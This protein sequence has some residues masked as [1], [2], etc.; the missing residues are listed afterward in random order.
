[1]AV[2]SRIVEMKFNYQQFETGVKS[3]LGALDRLAE[4]LHL[5]GASKGMDE[6]HASTKKL[7]FSP[8]MASVDS[9]TGRFT[10]LGVAGVAALATIAN[11]AVLTGQRMI[12]SVT[13]EPI[14]GGLREYETKLG[15]IQTIL[16]NTSASG[17]TLK[18]VNSTL[19]EL[20]KYSDQTIYNF[21]EMAKNIGTFT[22][23]G[24]GLETATS[25]IKGIA[26]LAALSGSSSQQAST[27]MYQLSQ[28]ISAGKVSLMDWNSVVN[29][30]MGGAIFQRSLAETAVAMGKL[31]KSA[32]KLEGAMKNVKIN[33]Q[34][35][36]ESIS[37]ENGGPTWLT[38]DV[39]TT[40][41]GNFTGDLKE[42]DLVAQ[43]FTKSQAQAIMAQAKTAKEAATVVK[44]GSQLMGTLKEAAESGWSQ[45]WEIILGDFEEAKKLWTG[46]NNVFGG[47]INASAEARN[48]LLQDWK[49]LGGRTLLITGI[50]NA[51][52]ALMAVV[53]PLKDAFRAIFPAKTGA[54][55]VVM[56]LAF[57]RFTESLK[58]GGETA[59]NLR[60]T[61]AGVFAIFSILGQ[62]VGALFG[63]FKRLF[64]GVS[65][66]AGGILSFTAGIG[67]WLVALDKA[68]KKGDVFNV[69]FQKLGDILAVPLKL[70][71][72]VARAIGSLFSG[73]DAGAGDKIGAAAD[74][75]GKRFQPL[76]TLGAKIQ[77]FFAKVASK[78]GSFGDEIAVAIAAVGDAIANI[79]A[80]ENFDRALDLLNTG[81]LGGI[82]LM[83][84][85]FMSGDIFNLGGGGGGGLL[86]SIRD[87]F[88]GLTDAL[89]TMQASVKADILL[90][91]AAAVGILA[92][93]LVILSTIDPERLAISLGAVAVG[94]ALLTGALV[95]L[96][97]TL[98]LMG[99]LKL[100]FIAAGLIGLA[101]ALLL[102]SI[103]LKIIA[104]MT[105]EEMLRGLAGMAGMLIL[106]TAASIPL[107]ANAGGM[108]RA[109]AAMILLGTAMNIMAVALKLFATISWGEMVRGLTTMA[110]TLVVL[111]VGMRLM[112]KNM[113]MQAVAL[114]ILA[115]ALSAMAGALKLF[116]LFSLGDAAGGLVV[117][118]GSL[119][120]LAAGLHMMPKNM[121]LQS[122][123]LVAVGVALNLLAVAIK[124]M[125]G[126]SWG[127][128][129][130]GLVTLAGS[131]IILAVGLAAMTG[132]LAG[133]AALVVATAALA[134]L[135]P[136]LI[137]LGNLSW[138]TIVTGLGALAGIFVVLGAAGFILAPVVPVILA[139]A[140]SMLLIGAGMALA[141][142]G[143]LAFATA[144]GIAAAVGAAIISVLAGI[145]KVFV[146]AIPG[147]LEAFGKGIVAFAK[148]I[149]GAGKEFF[150]AI[151]TVLKSMIDA[152]AANAPRIIKS[153]FDILN[154]FIKSIAENA[155]KIIKGVADFLVGFLNAIA[156]NAPR[157]VAAF[158]NMLVGVINAIAFSLPRFVTA[159]ANLIIMFLR[160]VAQNIGRVVTA[161]VNVVL[162][163]MA[164]LAKE[165]P[166]LADSG[167]KLIISFIDGLTRAINN[168]SAALG[169]AG[170]RLAVAIV[171]GMVR[172]LGAGIG[173]ITNAARNLAKSALDAAKN[174]LGIASPSKEFTKV[175]EFTVQGFVKGLM[176]GKEE[177]LKTW[178]TMRELL[179]TAMNGSRDDIAKLKK[180]MT[181][182]KKSRAEDDASVIATQK[183]LSATRK[184]NAADMDV[185]QA[186]LAKLQSARKVD[187]AAV[188]AAQ[189][190]ISKARKGDEAEIARLEKKLVSLNAARKA[191]TA[192]ILETNNA[193]VQAQKELA[194]SS[195]AYAEVN[196]NLIDER[197]K[198][199]GLADE[200]EKIG[201]QLKTAS[202]TLDAARK[203]RDDFYASLQQKYGDLPQLTGETKLQEY[204]ADLEKK[205]Q[206]TNEFSI[207]VQKLRDL[208]LNDESYKEILEKGID[209]LPFVNEL[210]IGGKSAVD[211]VN[212]LTRRLEVE[213]GNLGRHAS[214]ALYQAGVD[215]AQGVVQGIQSQRS[216]VVRQMEAL[217]E[218]MLKA[219]KD[220]LGI[221][222]PSKEMALLG[223]YSAKGMA[224]GLKE[225][226]R[227]VETAAA[228]V[229]DLAVMAMNESLQG[230]TQILAADIDVNPVV[231]PV[232]DLTDFRKEAGQ[233]GSILKSQKISVD[234]AYSS[235]KIA[236]AEYR[237]NQDAALE[238]EEPDVEVPAP[239]T[240]IQNNM[241]P[242][243]LPPADIYR[244]TKSQL[245]IARRKGERV[246]ARST[247]S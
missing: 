18:D 177:I 5:K 157:V 121:L 153:F 101:A 29:A 14:M 241:S 37:A 2:D 51:F 224:A 209:A 28:A 19:N 200:Y 188:L 20:N 40:A 218:A 187:S 88:D 127:E 4:K 39:L 71:Q 173:Q 163:F 67:M 202:D 233:M 243:A 168:N 190:A 191:D 125:G 184:Q 17:A 60:R 123:A 130:K 206:D 228:D 41:L 147:A 49:D 220:K 212:L 81:L 207:A 205:V 137:V 46:V 229:G 86:D 42:A 59:Q 244:G 195:G 150:G 159:G 22:A 164:A 247:R 219:I 162:S 93:S 178:T 90:K 106:L 232:L 201:E 214:A 128:I 119:V 57:V 43:G 236:S 235:A 172:G 54:D 217:A 10:A 225:G 55:L 124:S 231:A 95:V 126:M 73:F 165:I 99:S 132:S 239:V 112:P 13:T 146:A 74:T 96:T 161:A 53:K 64:G 11:Q 109:G 204:M 70:L 203:T 47:M 76:F 32:L 97:K 117:L 72:A 113:V 194:K 185:L 36:R 65:E 3:V 62:I 174:F 155:P 16:A 111:A 115:V 66:G 169:A 6:V 8:I 141:G 189:N 222:S 102:M 175:G 23:A 84:K 26:N 134:V 143:V 142:A 122:V 108:M 114:N 68:L 107:A 50:Q 135:V 199:E 170:G 52:E 230:L 208:G 129:A 193:L 242:K 158:V 156:Q 211:E 227:F 103:S 198:L 167:A 31:P 237:M 38:S 176:G 85:K 179:A 104:S 94:F 27:A 21:G 213:A 120:V 183:A 210:L 240:Y 48:K 138:Q 78:L 24:V 160:G 75:I 61:F 152:I 234:A 79:F 118:A 83:L 91:I 151:S 9:V 77:D 131:L 80:G 58:I 63:Q 44:S 34:S 35:F 110:G 136:I 182:L 105:W 166:R 7:N 246:N 238:I 139:L 69:L 149:A 25:S 15:S 30:G 221:K 100:P 196:K 223:G 186:K 140:A 33:G 1:M 145:L 180:K 116:T 216:A 98:G 133:A 154:G 226:S 148:V 92:A 89:K 192:A 197:H 144:L 171:E 181:E 56:T 245:S 12:K 45:S 87:S 82:L 215:S